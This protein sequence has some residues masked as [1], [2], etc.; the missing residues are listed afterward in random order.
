MLNQV[1]YVGR[2]VK[3]IEL[4]ENENGEKNSTMTLAVN[5]PFKNEQGIYETDFIDAVISNTIASQTAEYCKKGDMVGVRGR[6]QSKMED[7]KRLLYIVVDKITF[8]SSK[9]PEA[10]DDLSD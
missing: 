8:L 6:L 4:N 2:L 7:N 5:R 3:D 9:K 1:I 10:G